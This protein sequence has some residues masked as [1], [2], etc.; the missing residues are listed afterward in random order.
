MSK[1]WDDAFKGDN[2]DVR[3]QISQKIY[4]IVGDAKYKTQDEIDEWVD[5]DVRRLV[6]IPVYQAKH[7]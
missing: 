4:L 6:G 7:D 2:H 5:S 3:G 1:V